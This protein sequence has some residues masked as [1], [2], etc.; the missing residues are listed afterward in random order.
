V[1]LVAG[2]AGA[3]KSALIG[4]FASDV[5]DVAQVLVGA[6]DAL[7]T[8]RPLG[9]LLDIAPRLG[10]R[11]RR[12]LESGAPRH[13]LFAGV[14][15]ELG[16]GGRAHVLV[17]EDMHWADEATLDLLRYVARRIG[18]RRA[19]LIVTYRD[20]ELP[21]LHPL[22][23]AIGDIAT[24]ETV[25]R[26]EVPPL[27]PSAVA[28]LAAPAGVDAGNLYRQTGGNAFFV[29]EVLASQVRGVPPSVRDAVLARA[30]RLSPSARRAL[31]AAAVIGV[32]VDLDILEAAEHPEAIAL[33]ECQAQGMLRAI[34]A[35]LAFRHEIARRTIVEAIPVDR[36]RALHGRILA[37][38]VARRLTPDE[39]AHVAEH[40]EGAADGG[41][42]LKYATAAAE[43]AIPLGAH[44]EAASQFERALRWADRLG[45]RERASLFE[46][47]SRECAVTDRIDEA[48]RAAAESL[49]LWRS[50]ADRLKEGDALRWLSRLAWM[51]N[52]LDQAE[53]MAVSAVELLETRE[54]GRELAMAYSNLAQVYGL[55]WRPEG[56]ERW[57]PAAIELASRLGDTETLIHAM[58]NVGM[59][60][61][62]N[63]DER[64][65]SMAED[66]IR[67]A[68]QLGLHEHVG[69]GLFNLFRVAVF[70]YDHARAERY[71]EIGIAYY[72]EHDLDFWRSYLL[73]VR[74]I[75]L[76]DRGRWEEAQELAAGVLPESSGV[77]IRRMMA[78]YVLGR[79]AV[80]RGEPDGAERIDEALE[81]TRVLPDFQWLLPLRAARAE[82]AFLAGELTR[83]GDEAARAYAMVRPGMEWQ[84]GELAYWLWQAG[85]LEQPPEDIAAPYTLQISGRP[86]EAAEV[87]RAIGCPY[88]EARALAESEDEA[89][90]RRGF[91]ALD[92]LGARPA[93]G[94]TLRRL[95]ERGVR[96]IKRGPHAATRANVWGLSARE[97]EILRLVADGLRNA[98]IASRLFI[99]E[100]TVDHHV[101]AIFAKLSV[102]SRTQA[103][104]VARAHGLAGS[105]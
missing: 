37:A 18:D 39:F 1:V 99:S 47:Y 6:C 2:E 29:T 12:L 69:R 30:A 49:E 65:I 89:A 57:G 9:P 82:A 21:P 71:F 93:A 77:A 10:T 61:F 101:A 94:R 19:M 76:L 43:R 38:L 13:E 5:R 97:L 15:A 23:V 28:T 8:A 40:A 72:R 59:T 78:L 86:L 51:S 20:D 92:A 14:L 3:G 17:F 79:I 4:R 41:A 105:E 95:R 16:I 44:R 81:A 34:D 55:Q 85:R 45:D 83:A 24:S 26:L 70:R 52:D 88:E 46:R 22:R 53:R 36:R 27:S 100:R 25:H 31:E 104:R 50:L 60:R 32:R 67:Q 7:T 62:E 75:I 56:V 103:A 58:S 87:W 54:A 73:A 90:M 42:V 98:D 91:A 33:E 11:A 96:D 80:R 74:A 48:R 64:G 68:T 84:R 66:A 63:G 35:D 102:R